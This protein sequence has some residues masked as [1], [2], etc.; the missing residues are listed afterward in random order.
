M[1]TGIPVLGRLAALVLLL[2]WVGGCG[3]VTGLAIH[4]VV[5]EAELPDA[6]IQLDLAYRDDAEADPV[7]HKLDFF[8]PEG[9]GWPT[10]VFVHGGSWTSGDKGMKVGDFGV[11]ANIG[12]FYAARGIGVAVINYRLQPLPRAKRKLRKPYLGWR[13]QIDDVA[14][15]IAFVQ[16]N[17]AG[18]GG[19]PDRFFLMGHSAGG[20]LVSYVGLV[21]GPLR[22][23]GGRP[24]AVCGI[25]PV[26][27]AGFDLADQQTYRLGADRRYY[28]ER[29]EA[30]QADGVWQREASVV[31]YLDPPARKPPFLIFYSA[32]EW[33]SLCYQ[34]DLFAGRL[35]AAGI[36]VDKR[37]IR[38]LSH[39]RMALAI[40]DADAELDDLILAFIRDTPCP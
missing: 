6:Q 28:R 22:L 26:S 29:F 31:S 14:R 4:A 3:T 13:E 10:L 20:Q 40:S 5:G 38:D 36:E 33:P 30:G 21:D 32:A 23:A 17:V 7:K 27:G 15:A 39:P 11:Y 25:I 1:K 8:R 18:W 9:T 34:N 35:K 12:R 2:P 37:V 24:E 16:K 19:D